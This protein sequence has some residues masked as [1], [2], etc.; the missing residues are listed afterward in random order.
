MLRPNSATQDNA[1]VCR[2][3]QRGI[4]NVGSFMLLE[5]NCRTTAPQGD[6]P[7]PG[8]IHSLQ[9]DHYPMDQLTTDTCS[10]GEAIRRHA[11]QRDG[12][13]ALVSARGETSWAQLDQ[14]ATRLAHLYL[15]RGA[16][17]DGLV[18]IAL[19]NDLDSV[20]A[21]IACWKVGAT[22]L[23]LPSNLTIA[24]RLALLEVAE[25]RLLVG[26]AKPEESPEPNIPPRIPS[27]LAESA[28]CPTTPLPENVSRYCRATCSGGSTGTPKIIVD[29]TPAV[30]DPD[31]GTY[32][33]PARSTTLV[34]G[35]LYHSGP[36]LNS[37]WTLLGGGCL[38]LMERFEPEATLQLITSRQPH[39]LGLVPTMMLR[40]WRLPD[41]IRRACDFSSLLRV[42]SSGAP[43]PPWLMRAWIDWLGP[44]RMFEAYGASERVGGTLISGSEWLRHPGSVGRATLGRQV[45]IFDGDGQVVPPGVIGR[46]FLHGG[47]QGDTFHYLGAQPERSPDGWVTLGDLGYLDEEGYLYLTDRETDMVVTGGANVYPAEIEAAIEAFPGVLCAVVIGLPDE[48]LGQRLHAIIES[49]Q[50][51]DQSALHTFLGERLSRHKLPRSLEL[52]TDTLRNDAGKVRRAALRAA[53]LPPD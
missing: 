19:P 2:E 13:I 22:P 45:G 7:P 48:D 27:P 9:R 40:I 1:K 30:C 39:Y 44:E 38:V 50:H 35:P 33:M 41:T 14:L 28:H 16:S 3:L 24:E 31:S 51:L 23:V 29:H 53:R 12:D 52:V 42:V 20:V 46:V 4:G 10:W 34:P 49:E 17:A 43:C 11:Q 36:F 37:F 18:A 25:P 15:A 21:V 26:D 8:Q 32:T 47:N 6:R 5:K